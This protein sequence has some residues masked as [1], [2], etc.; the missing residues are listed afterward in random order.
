YLPTLFAG[1]GRLSTL[2]TV[3]VTLA[4]GADRRVIGVYVFLQSLLPLVLYGLAL[5]LP[6]AIY[7][8]RRGLARSG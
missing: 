1:A 3:A 7:A 4:A 6:A 5:L 8:N 2:T